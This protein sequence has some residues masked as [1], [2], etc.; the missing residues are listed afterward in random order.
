MKK[1]QALIK[2]VLII[3]IVVSTLFSTVSFATSIEPHGVISLTFDDGAKSQYDYAF[4]L[5]QTRGIPGTFYVITDSIRDLSTDDNYYMNISELQTLQ[6]YGSEIGS[7]SKTHSP[8]TSLTD[9]EIQAESQISKQVLQSFGLLAN[10]FCYP[11]GDRNEYTDSIVDDYYRS[12]RTVWNPNYVS[13]LPHSQFLVDAN[14]YD[15]S[16]PDI[17]SYLKWIVD[18]AYSNNQWAVILFHQILPDANNKPFAISTQDFES[19]LDYIISKNVLTLTIDQ[20][21]DLTSPPSTQDTYTITAAVDPLDAGSISASQTGQYNLNDVVLLTPTANPGYTF[22]NWN[23]DLV[24]SINPEIIIIDGN[25]TVTA[26]FTKITNPTS[27]PNPTQTH[28]P[29]SVQTGSINF[30]ISEM[31]GVFLD[32]VFILLIISAETAI[33]VTYHNRKKKSARFK[34]K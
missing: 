20:A 14:E 1:T 31:S 32:T 12:A 10:N 34:L 2:H 19:L 4:P 3:A 29:L 9:S 18:Q 8:L 26:T 11:F 25:K 22:S 15:T 6:K 33:M 13:P 28:A 23:G 30:D 7:H 24:S 21:L 27:R 5:M 17:L 16:F